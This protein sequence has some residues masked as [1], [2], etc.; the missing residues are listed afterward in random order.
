MMECRADSYILKLNATKEVNMMISMPTIRILQCRSCG[1]VFF[2]DS[3]AEQHEVE[4]DH[5]GFIKIGS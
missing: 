5:P 4:Y 1:K 2:F 3:D